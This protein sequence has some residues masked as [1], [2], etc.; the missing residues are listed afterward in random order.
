MDEYDKHL[1]KMLKQHPSH[2]KEFEHKGVHYKISYLSPSG[3]V[4]VYSP[5]EG[6]SLKERDEDTVEFK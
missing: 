5:Q 1:D 4:A 6:E 3:A 2:L